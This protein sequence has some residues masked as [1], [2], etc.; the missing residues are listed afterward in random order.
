MLPPTLERIVGVKVERA[1]VG[2]DM[3][4]VVR[5]GKF[6][7]TLVPARNWYACSK[8]AC[9][10]RVVMKAKRFYWVRQCEHP[11]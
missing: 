9:A 1:L 3:R 7:Y 10:G 6:T 5:V 4:D 8:K 2:K 11:L